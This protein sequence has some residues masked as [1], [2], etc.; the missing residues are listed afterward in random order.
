MGTVVYV[1]AYYHC[2]HCHQG[3]FPTD[4]EFG[5]EDRR[6][7][8]VREVVSL[9]GQLNPFDDGATKALPK[10]SGLSISSGT[11]R[12]ITEEVGQDVADR[13]AAGES[14]GPDRVWDWHR[15]AQGRRVGYVSLDATAVPQQGP[16]AERAEGRMPWVGEVFNPQPTHEPIRH[17]RVGDARYVSGLMSLLEVSRQL[18]R[19]CRAVGLGQVDVIVAL[20]DGGNGLEN[21]LLETVAGLG[22]AKIEFVLDFH[23]VTDHVQ[24][25]ANM[26]W[27]TDASARQ[28][29]VE[30]WCHTLKHQGGR[31]LYEGLQQWDVTP[32][33]A[34]IQQAHES[35]LG[36]LRNNLHRMD[37][38]R[39]IARG[40]QI[41]SGMIE[42]ACKTVV[43]QRLKQ[44][45]MRWRER[46]TTALCQLR[47]L[48][49]SEPAV[50]TAYWSRAPAA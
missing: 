27:P 11:V 45:G 8:A 30:A 28:A 7:P 50:W 23:H 34:A 25:F 37:Y 12:R 47:A 20:S 46:G 33:S 14:F 29:Q 9:M 42:S 2:P 1:R 4:A 6:T 41:G 31:T 10:L 26:L 36:Y 18:R 19:E 16:H 5:M 13:R 24:E 38:P 44:G 40:W 32:A 39:Y 48:Y 49:R 3:D 17:R 35:L 15:D 22:P 21:A 43:C